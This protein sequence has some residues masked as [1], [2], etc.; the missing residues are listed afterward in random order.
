MIVFPNC[1]INL[2]LN[3]L[4]KRADGYHNLETIFYPL[5]LYDALEVVLAANATA[6]YTLV[7]TGMELQGDAETNL[8]VKAYN[9][10]KQ[11]FPHLPAVHIHL[12]KTI[13][14]GAGLG[15]GSADGAFMLMLLNDKFKLHLTEHSLLQYALMLG[16]DCPFFIINQPCLGQQRGEVLHPVPLDLSAYKIVVINPGIHVNTGW[17]FIQVNFSESRDLQ[18]AV[19]QPVEAWR[20]LFTNDF[21]LPVFEKY[22]AIKSLKEHLY[23][24]NAVYASMSGSGSTV[25]GI[26]KKDALIQYPELPPGSF[27]KEIEL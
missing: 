11:D 9:L 13:P 23:Q 26:F 12:H 15:G 5:S 8:C 22:S 1:K 3:I 20:H 18:T 27:T 6:P 4:G 16:S 7:V 21:E 19:T 2:G 14:T 25:F 10:L 24:Q 17:A